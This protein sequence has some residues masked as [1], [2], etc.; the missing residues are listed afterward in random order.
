MWANINIKISDAK[1]S[2]KDTKASREKQTSG[3]A[4]TTYCKQRD[5]KGPQSVWLLCRVGPY[6]QA[7][8]QG[9]DMQYLKICPCKFKRYSHRSCFQL[10]ADRSASSLLRHR[11]FSSQTKIWI[12]HLLHARH[13]ASSATHFHLGK[14]GESK[15]SE[16]GG[17]SYLALFSNLLWQKTL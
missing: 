3:N 7:C 9:P 12:R 6:L 17:V 1:W 2:Q 16:S 5:A 15:T 14:R 10:S 11:C 13:S 8:V 4:K